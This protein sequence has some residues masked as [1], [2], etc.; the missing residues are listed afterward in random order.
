MEMVDG[1]GEK[2]REIR[3]RLSERVVRAARTI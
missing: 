2:R 3:E 1:G